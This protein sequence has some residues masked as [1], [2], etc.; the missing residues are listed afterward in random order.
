MLVPL[1]WASL[2]TG[3]V[4]LF[5]IGF[6]P[7]F[8][9]SHRPPASDFVG[10]DRA[11]RLLLLADPQLEGDARV[12]EQG[13]Y[14]HLNNLFNAAY[15]KHIFTALTRQYTPSN[16]AILGDLLSSELIDE[17]E[18]ARRVAIFKDSFDG[19]R[20]PHGVWH[21]VGNHD[22]GYGAKATKK[23]LRR[24]E[25]AFGALN[26]AQTLAELPVLVWDDVNVDGA[27]SSDAQRLAWRALDLHGARARDEGLPWILLT[28]IPLF[29]DAPQ[30]TD[31]PEVV[32][33]QGKRGKTVVETQT[34]L[35]RESSDRV[36]ALR[37][38]IIFTGHDHDGCDFNHTLPD[39]T[40]VP[41]FTLRSVMGDYGGHAHILDV[42]RMDNED[43]SSRFEFAHLTCDFIPATPL[44]LILAYALLLVIGGAA[45]LLLSS[46]SRAAP[47]GKVKQQ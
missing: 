27:R 3:S 14:G 28:H 7:M 37:P 19:S 36:L 31:D 4:L 34:M 21:V 41:E 30:C 6:Y 12:E 39:G 5:A 46:C 43:G 2:A 1:A 9:C 20:V 33:K 24:H 16:A 45:A 40:V 42:V 23:R 8:L 13:V 18:H 35:S 15:F 38:G 29:K 32:S 10:K 25:D 47:A 26:S 22:I 17:D 44:V 11:A